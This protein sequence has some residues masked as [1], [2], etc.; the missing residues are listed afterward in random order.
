MPNEGQN[1][2]QHTR[3]VEYISSADMLRFSDT[4]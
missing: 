4:I 3:I 1:D 2:Q